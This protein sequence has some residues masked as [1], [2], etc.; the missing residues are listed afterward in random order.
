[1]PDRWQVGEAAVRRIHEVDVAGLGRWLLPDATPAVV[2][3]V[4]WLSPSYADG[5]G[6]LLGSVHTFAVELGGLRVLVD[7]GVGNDKSRPNP[8]W[9]HLDTP[10][11]D[12]LTAAGFAPE[13]VDLVVNTHL[14][15]D[16]VGWNTRLDAGVWRP[17]FPNARYLVARTEYEY[18]TGVNLPADRRL[19][20]ADSVDPVRDAGQLDLVEVPEAE[21]EVADGLRL[22]PAPGHTPGQVAVRIDSGENSALITG[23]CV[24]HPVQLARPDI[25]SSADFDPAA[26]ARTRH[27]LLATVAGTG[28]LLLGSHFSPPTGG[29]VR[30]EGAAFRLETGG[31]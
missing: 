30:R 11:L 20:F 15:M 1:M 27:E 2:S 23:D 9:D 10:Y 12:R 25:C 4:P 7:T 14:H 3:R 29:F 26:A 6:H 8:D 16:H 18:W 19:L 22:V 5:S 13:S 21:V 31:R 28:V 24:H 17:T